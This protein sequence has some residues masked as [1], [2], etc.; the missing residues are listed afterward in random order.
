[1]YLLTC[2]PEAA[3]DRAEEVEIGFDSGTP[4][5]VNGEVMGAIGLLETLNELAG[6]HGVG[7]VDLV[8]DRLVGMKSRG[9]YETPGGTL[10]YTAHSELEQL[11]LD[12]RTLA[13]KDL[14]A[15][16]Y[17]DLVYE[18]RW[19]SV[20]REAMDALV[21]RTQERV[22]GSVRLRLY[23]GG[24]TVVSRESA[25]SLYDERFVTFGEDD[26]Y[27][28]AD[29]AGFIRLYGLPYRVAGLK[30]RARVAAAPARIA[31]VA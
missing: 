20:E 16:R 27:D 3:P 5:S 13:L 22:T 30:E 2:S 9:V 28:Q 7:R 12:R 14:L 25:W 11:V 31:E 23:K 4:I 18:G 29:A 26:V 8:E 21:E 17:A 6:R 10:L 19:W 24:H 15:P 1:M